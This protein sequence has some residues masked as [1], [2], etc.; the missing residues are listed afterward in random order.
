M[1]NFSQTIVPPFS[2]NIIAN[3]GGSQIMEFYSQTNER[4]EEPIPP[5]SPP[6]NG[7][8]KDSEQIQEQQRSTSIQGFIPFDSVRTK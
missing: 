4:T 2:I 8:Q 1:N 5:L 6:S 7:R 3:D